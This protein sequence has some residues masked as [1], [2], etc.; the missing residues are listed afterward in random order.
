MIGPGNESFLKCP[1]QELSEYMFVVS[2]TSA[3]ARLD[4]RDLWALETEITQV[5]NDLNP[6]VD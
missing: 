6:Y 1:D 3:F 4:F 2:G 5:V